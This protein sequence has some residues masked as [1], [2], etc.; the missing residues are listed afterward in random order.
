MALAL[1]AAQAELRNP[2]F[3]SVNPHFKS[4][5][6]SLAGV[7]DTVTPVLTKHGLSV[8]QWPETDAQGHTLVTTMLMH[9]SCQWMQSSLHVPTSKP[10]AHGT[11]SSITYA[12]RYALMAACGVVGDVDDDGAAAVQKPSYEAKIAK[13]AKACIAAHAA[14]D[15]WGCYEA[16]SGVTDH[17]ERLYLWELLRDHSAVRS[18]IKEYAEYEKQGAKK[19]AA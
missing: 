8:T 2:A 18:M 14:D 13:V 11:G 15:G 12:R 17:E 3:D 6:A 16:A 10:D 9:S 5:F 7:R 1:V 4:K 19:V